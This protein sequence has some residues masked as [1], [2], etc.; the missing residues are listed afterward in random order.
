VRGLI[1]MADFLKG[2][3]GFCFRAGNGVSF[4]IVIPARVWRVDSRC[5]IR[6]SA[7]IVL[8]QKGFYHYCPE[9]L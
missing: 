1:A 5:S 2:P 3:V 7:L 8:A 6:G 4:G 9:I